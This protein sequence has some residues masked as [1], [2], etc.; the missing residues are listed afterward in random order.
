MSQFFT[1]SLE[2]PIGIIEITANE[3]SITSV[4]FI[5]NP[6]KV[7]ENA[8]Q[9]IEDCKQQLTEYFDE[10]RTVFDIP[11]RFSGTDFQNKVWTLLQ[12]IAYGKTVSYLQMAKILGDVKAIR[13]AASANGKNPFA[14]IVPCH[15][16]VGSNQDLVGY[17]GGLWRKRW[18]LEHE[19]KIANGVRS[20]FDD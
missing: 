13:A 10:T 6:V 12:T 15:R 9:V 8:N 14:I 2:S 19:Q 5:D 3:K 11:L 4:L 17:A 1:S 20:L 16:V 18:L 7:N